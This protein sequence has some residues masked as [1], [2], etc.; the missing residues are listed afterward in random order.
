MSAGETSLPLESAIIEATILTNQAVVSRKGKVTLAVGEN[1]VVLADLPAHLVE[2]SVRV[3]GA[4]PAGA[5]ILGTDIRKAYSAE[6][7][8]DKLRTLQR[9]LEELEGKDTALAHDL[10]ELNA[11]KNLLTS[12]TGAAG[13]DLARGFSR[14][15][16]EVPDLEKAFSWIQAQLHENH[17]ALRSKTAAR[18]ELQKSLS[19]LRSE[20]QQLSSR[21]AR[22]SS[23]IEVAVETPAAGPFE[24]TV[25]YAVPGASWTPVYDTRVFMD[26]GKTEVAYFGVVRQTTGEAWSGTA[27]TLS[28]A[29][30]SPTTTLPELFPWYLSAYAPP[31]PPMSMVGS[32]AFHKSRGEAGGGPPAAAPRSDDMEDAKKKPDF[33]AAKDLT[34]AS[35]VA[36]QVEQ[37]GETVVYRIQRPADLPSGAPPKKLIIGRYGLPVDITFL[38]VPKLVPEVYT[39]AELKN[40][41]E[42]LFLPG[43]MSLFADADFIGASTIE[44]VAPG[45][46]FK[47][48]LGITKAIKV[49]REL[50]SREVSAGGVISKERVTRYAYRIK[51]EN[52]RKADAK[53]SV[54]DQL[55]VSRHEK[56][57]VLDVRFGEGG[58]PTE[59]TDLGLLTWTMTLGA[60]K[61][62]SIE[63][64]YTVSH[65]VDMTISGGMD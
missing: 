17:A 54:K 20:V 4:G 34:R 50:V 65:P 56:I 37:V 41:S 31:P 29:P 38:T 58:E 64:S 61:K 43:E 44:S 52:N 23:V 9:S 28:T 5:K 10:E 16:I 40:N 3:S 48:S 18:K 53:L 12:M 60:G 26:E 51:L 46:K 42:S 11:S 39:S 33:G 25:E 49:K 15:K 47:L 55:P 8:D 27:V 30:E 24:L 14:K 1:R 32:G 45:E 63:Y 21:A 22:V 57:K 36:A 35:Q 6:I 19:A 2:N 62:R 7:K 59:R 13:T